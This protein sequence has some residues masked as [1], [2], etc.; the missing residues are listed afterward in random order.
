M[1]DKTSKLADNESNAGD[2]AP[3]EA[4][5]YEDSFMIAE[6]Q[7]EW[8]DMFAEGTTAHVYLGR[9]RGRQVAIKKNQHR[10]ESAQGGDSACAE[11]LRSRSYGLAACSAP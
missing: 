5:Q 9:L 1:G 2:A 7:L 8:G 10:S 4:G 11:E 3:A 6:G